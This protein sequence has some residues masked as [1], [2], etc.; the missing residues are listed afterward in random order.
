MQKIRSDALSAQ[1]PR[2][3]QSARSWRLVIIILLGAQLSVSCGGLL[4]GSSDN[5]TNPSTGA[6]P[7]PHFEPGF[8]L[9]SVEQDVELGRQSAQ[10]IA[11]QVP[12]LR[13]EQT[14]NYVRQ[15]GARLAARAPGHRFPYQFNVVASREV[16]AFALPGGFIF[17]NAGAIMNARNEGELAGVMAHE[18]MHVALRH[19]TNQ[20]SKAYVAQAGIGIISGILGSGEN[21]D[22]AQ[23]INTIGGAGAN[24]VFL[25]FGRTAETQSDLAGARIMAEAG[26]DP[27]DMAAF[28]RTL[29][30][31]GG[32][33][34]PEF[35]SDHPDPGNR[36]AAINEALPNLPISG[37]PTRD[38]RDFQQV[39]ARL[40]GGA[41]RSS[42]TDSA[43]PRRTGP[44]DPSNNRAGTRPPPPSSNLR[45]LTSR[46]RAFSLRFPD[47]WDALTG[48]ANDDAN[49]I[50]APR[51]A[52][53]QTRNG[54]VVTHGLF[55]GLLPAQG[56]LQGTT[57][58]F[59]QQ[60]IAANPDFQVARQPQ[61]IEFAGRSGLATVI[62]GPSTVTGVREMNVIFT[63]MTGDNR[64]F[65]LITIAP[66]GEVQDYQ[67]TFE[68][69][70][71][72]LR[73]TQ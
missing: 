39:R 48:S 22:M 53:G 2:E 9:F 51:G 4:P 26:Y 47:N 34:A 58:R 49:I 16:N 72:S 38:T 12:L 7:A 68:R 13:D 56:D 8:N 1:R 37:N 32:Q 43:D 28:F 63:T 60:Q 27:R 29:Q 18:I 30:A 65:Y 23:V 69:I 54:V 52:Y 6:R 59:V 14:V 71:A 62:V 20:A 21:P 61:T 36:I 25:K 3:G 19:G 45:E 70:I 67:A 17:V 46:D 66:E 5:G 55:V 64:L 15:L 31:Q 41:S 11:Q 57:T 73:L 35:L 42:L 50:I 24:M 10:Q 44:S 40:T 33:R